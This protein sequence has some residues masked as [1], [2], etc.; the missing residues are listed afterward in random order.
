MTNF[1]YVRFY[2]ENE[3]LPSKPI[4]KPTF[5]PKLKHV[6][7]HAVSFNKVAY[8]YNKYLSPS[9]RHVPFSHFQYTHS[10]LKGLHAHGF[11]VKEEHLQHPEELG[12]KEE[13]KK[14]TIP[15]E[16]VYEMGLQNTSVEKFAIANLQ[17]EAGTVNNITLH[18]DDQ[19]YENVP[20]NKFMDTYGQFVKDKHTVRVAEQEIQTVDKA[21]SLT[22]DEK[23]KLKKRTN[24]KVNIS[25]NQNR[26][27]P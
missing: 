3:R 11:T 10:H 14:I 23:D 17:E 19:K 18:R 1:P 9:I 21:T 22:A 26:L 25:K 13:T 8:P 2:T 24:L 4:H 6:T 20:M 7:T 27:N 5:E 15:N 12:I 16:A